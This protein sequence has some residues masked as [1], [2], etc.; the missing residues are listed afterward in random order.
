[1]LLSKDPSISIIGSD[2]VA[3]SDSSMAF[4]DGTNTATLSLPASNWSANGSGTLFTYKNK[5]APSGP[6]VV[7]VV[8][9]KGGLLKVVAKGAAIPVPNGPGTIDVVLSLDGGTNTYCM[10]F[11]GTGDGTKFLAKDSAAGTVRTRRPTPLRHQPRL[12]RQR[13]VSPTS[14]RPG[15]RPCAIA[16]WCSPP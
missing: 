14:R 4:D 11:T 5:A 7:K 1:M 6:S 16:T 13:S 8:K 12:R 10:T 3:G 15:P 9:V 2:P